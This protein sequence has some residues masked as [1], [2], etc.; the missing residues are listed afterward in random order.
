MPSELIDICGLSENGEVGVAARKTTDLNFTQNMVNWEWYSVVWKQRCK[1]SQHVPFLRLKR[2]TIIVANNRRSS[3]YNHPQ[4]WAF[5]KVSYLHWYSRARYFFA[6]QATLNFNPG[7]LFNLEVISQ[8][9]PLKVGYN[10]ITDGEGESGYLKNRLP[11]I[12]GLIPGIIG[13]LGIA[14]GWWNLRM[15]RR[16][17]ASGIVFVIG[18][19]LWGYACT[20]LL[21]WSVE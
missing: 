13:L 4:S 3:Y 21:P 5:P 11:P 6:Q 20:V 16:L 18:I 14:W 12:K 1:V 10:G 7:A 19:A 2:R 15:E 8:I 9:F 17:P